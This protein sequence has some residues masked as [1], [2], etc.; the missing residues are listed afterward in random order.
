MPD[1]DLLD[2]QQFFENFGEPEKA[3]VH[4]T[5]G[6]VSTNAPSYIVDPFSFTGRAIRESLGALSTA[7]LIDFGESF[8]EGQSPPVIHTPLAVRAPEVIFGDEMDC[9]VDM[10]SMGCLV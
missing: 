7:K 5:D 3:V 10:W 1:L 4:S 6:V 8:L 9:R 2:E